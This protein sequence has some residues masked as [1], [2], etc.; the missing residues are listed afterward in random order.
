MKTR[1]Y[2]KAAKTPPILLVVTV[3][4]TRNK[5]IQAGGHRYRQARRPDLYRD[6]IGAPH[7]A[8]QK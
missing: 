7:A 4:L 3:T 5:L 1:I 8:V 6:V 2:R